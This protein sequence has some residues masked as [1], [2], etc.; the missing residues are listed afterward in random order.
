MDGPVLPA[1]LIGERHYHC[2]I[3]C[4]LA[5]A[6]HVHEL[7]AGNYGAAEWNDLKLSISLVTRFPPHMGREGVTYPSQ[8]QCARFWELY[9]PPGPAATNAALK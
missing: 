8:Q 3:H 9:P 6:D 7:D 2:M 4:E 1:K 5:F